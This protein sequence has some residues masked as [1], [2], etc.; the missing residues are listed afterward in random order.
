MEEFKTFREWSNSQ[1]VLG[2]YEVEK[3]FLSFI[4]RRIEELEKLQKNCE[5]DCERQSNLRV[6][7]ELKRLSK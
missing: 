1:V 5:T 6:I 3:N 7:N 2:L 4:N